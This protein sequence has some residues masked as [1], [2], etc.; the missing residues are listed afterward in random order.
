MRCMHTAEDQL[1][2][3]RERTI[4]KCYDMNESQKSNKQK[5]FSQWKEPDTKDHKLLDSN[6][7]CP[8]KANL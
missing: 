7:T 5:H 8:D 2:N 4:D 1:V 3:K 6:N